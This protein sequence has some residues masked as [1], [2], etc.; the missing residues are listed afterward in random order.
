M[1]EGCKK[2]GGKLFFF[3]KME[4]LDKARQE[5]LKLTPLER[6]KL[7]RE[8]YDVI[9]EDHQK[10]VVISVDSIKVKELGK[11]HIDLTKLFKRHPPIYETEEGK[12]VVD[13]DSTFETVKKR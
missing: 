3:V 5:S 1:K 11:Y 7:E 8:I 12:Y 9:G 4:N 13:L 10:P 2:C 6:K